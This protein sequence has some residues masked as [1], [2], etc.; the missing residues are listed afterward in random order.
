MFW[1]YR[2]PPPS[3]PQEILIPSVGEYHSI[4]AGTAQL[5]DGAVVQFECN[6]KENNDIEI[7][8][9]EALFH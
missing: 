4:F 2:P 3:H 5:S 1:P 6:Y 8:L 9:V 7:L